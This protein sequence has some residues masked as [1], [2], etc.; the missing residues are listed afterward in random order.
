[1]R[2]RGGSAGWRCS[3]RVRIRVCPSLERRSVSRVFDIKVPSVVPRHIYF[4]QQA[5]R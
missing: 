3:R 1:M 4:G 5:R 2:G